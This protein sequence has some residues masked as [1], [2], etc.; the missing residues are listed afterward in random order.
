[1]YQIIID[2]FEDNTITRHHFN[3]RIEMDNFL[4]TMSYNP[5]KEEIS[6]SAN[7]FGMFLEDYY[8]LR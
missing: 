2:N 4:S 6:V 1:M 5:E 7:G 8:C 3:T